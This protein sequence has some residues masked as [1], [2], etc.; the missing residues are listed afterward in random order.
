VQLPSGQLFKFTLAIVKARLQGDMVGER[1]GVVVG[2]AKVDAGK[3]AP[4]K[5]K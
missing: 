2:K 1:D 3:A 4:A 5:A